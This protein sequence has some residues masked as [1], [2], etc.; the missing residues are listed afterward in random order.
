MCPHLPPLYAANTGRSM[1][2]TPWEKG[3]CSKEKL[4]SF[5][6]QYCC[7]P[8][9]A[10]DYWLWWYEN[11]SSQYYTVTGYIPSNTWNDYAD[12]KGTWHQTVEQRLSGHFPS[13]VQENKINKNNIFFGLLW[14]SSWCIST[15]TSRS[16]QGNLPIRVLLPALRKFHAFSGT[17]LSI[18]SHMRILLARQLTFIAS[19]CFSLWS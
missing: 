10:S 2:P 16:S 14:N 9:I 15:W 7:I 11:V 17:G 1:S 6:P 8:S 19:F 13:S 5:F 3:F 12:L 4:K 18:L